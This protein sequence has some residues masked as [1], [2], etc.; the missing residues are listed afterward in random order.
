MKQADFE[1]RNLHAQVEGKPILRG[2]NLKINRGENHAMMGPNGSGKS[3]LANVIMGHPSY[4]VTRG[5][6]LYGGQNLVELEPEE[7]ARLGLFLAF[8]YPVAVPGVTVAKFLKSAVDAV[9]GAHGEAAVKPADFLKEIR[10]NISYLGIEEGFLNRYLND[11]FSGG[12]KKRMEIL[13][14]LTLKPTMAIMDETD[15]GL[16]VDALKVVSKGVNKLVG[17]RFGLLVI[18]HY[19]RILQYIRPDHLHILIDG[20]V[21]LSGGPELVT[22]VEE[23][24][25]DWIR[26]EFGQEVVVH[27]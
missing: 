1:I 17:D 23:N 9:R 11:G 8:Q 10:A 12:E 26:E 16:D 7:R 14:M 15:S 5:E 18:T 25:Y 22:K 13:Q 4:E 21:A 3:T 2:V 20:Q 6:I 19:E 24:G 27:T